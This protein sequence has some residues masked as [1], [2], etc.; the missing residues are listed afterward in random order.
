[1][2]F[3]QSHSIVYDSSMDR[4]T[5]II[6]DI[7]SIEKEG[8]IVV[9]ID[10]KCGS[11]KTTLA[12]RVAEHIDISIVHADDFT[13]PF[14]MKTPQRLSIPGGNL[15]SLRMLSDFFERLSEPVI[16]YHPFDYSIG[17]VSDR[18]ETVDKRIVIVEGSYSLLPVFWPYYD[19]CY[20]IDEPL[21]VRLRR[22]EKRVGRE[23]F[24]MF[25][26]KW[27][28]LEDLYWDTYRFD[29]IFYI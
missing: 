12:S 9:A 1:M 18:L 17:R 14:E 27:I 23:K 2:D 26:D 19:R 28:P 10:G 11:G 8:R 7:E 29:E 16:Q 15:D 20:I 4:V 6:G 5:R 21:D 24:Q 3:P 22:L 25:L 13:I